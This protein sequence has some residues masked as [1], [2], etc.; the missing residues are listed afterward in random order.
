MLVPGCCSCT[1]GSDQ[2]SQRAKNGMSK[3]SRKA[4]ASLREHLEQNET[5]L[6]KALQSIYDFTGYCFD[7]Q[8][9]NQLSFS[10]CSTTQQ[11]CRGGKTE[12][13][14]ALQPLVMLNLQ[15]IPNSLSVVAHV[16]GHEYGHIMRGHLQHP[17]ARQSR[18]SCCFLHNN[19][20]FSPAARL[21]PPSSPGSSV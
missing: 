3:D 15:R 18:A 11:E 16:I 2:G 12:P 5:N 4:C 7:V 17:N 14:R 13:Q 10:A 19:G 9:D 20:G 21:R 1:K 8:I 6:G